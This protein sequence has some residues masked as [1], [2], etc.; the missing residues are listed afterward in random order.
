MHMPS[1]RT[2]LFKYAVDTAAHS[3]SVVATT[4]AEAEAQ[5]PSDGQRAL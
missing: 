4:R 5:S 2:W 3:F 1:D